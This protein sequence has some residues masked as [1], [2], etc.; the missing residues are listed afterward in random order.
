MNLVQEP[1]SVST[2]ITATLRKI[3][4]ST[5]TLNTLSAILFII[6]VNRPVYDDVF[7]IIDVHA[8]SQKGV[9]VSTVLAQRNPP[10]P[11]S[12]LWMA[13][14]VRLLGGEE[15]RAARVAVL[16]SWIGLVAGVLV[17]APF[18]RFPQLWYCSLLCA[19]VFPHSVIATATLLTEGPALLFAVLGVIT[20]TEAMSRPKVTPSVFVLGLVGGLA[21]GAATVSRQYYLAL[22][23]AATVLGLFLLARRASEDRWLWLASMVFSLTVAVLPLLLLV[24]VWKGI[25]SPGIAAG[26]S[27]KQYHADVGVNFLRPIVASFCTGVY[28]IPLTFPAMRRLHARYGWLA[29]LGASIIGIAAIPFRVQLVDIGVLHTI[30]KT[31]SRLPVGGALAFGFIA[32]LNSYNAIALG[33]LV[34]EKRTVVLECPPLIISLLTVLF[35]VGEQAAVGGNIPFYDRYALLIA[36][37]LGLIA[38]SLIPK[39]TLPR[40][41]VLSAMYLMS[42]EILWRLPFSR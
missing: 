14:S 39:L 10:G 41:A 21:M 23:P 31:A 38:F 6:L 16:L 37:F 3:I 8:Y 7:N 27:Y 5:C 12:F 20:W 29:L 28:L 25:T 34:W 17:A 1:G 36:P 26:T 4:I 42:Q 33:L 9:S 11:L 32:I 24:L 13:A 35:Y 30:I 22:L 19:L 15:L 40:L 18:S 2:E